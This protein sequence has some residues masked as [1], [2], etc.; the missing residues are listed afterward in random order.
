MTGFFQLGGMFWSWAHSHWF[1]LGTSSGLAIGLRE[2]H[3][4]S[5]AMST[6]LPHVISPAS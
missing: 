6:S 3:L 1:H 4:P 2:A 5:D